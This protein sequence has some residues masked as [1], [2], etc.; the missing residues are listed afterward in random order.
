MDFTIIFTSE[1][2]KTG[3]VCQLKLQILAAYCF[4]NVAH[5][6]ELK[7]IHSALVNNSI[8]AS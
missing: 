3:M 4:H 8:F 7:L 5:K 6:D 1:Q 2:Y